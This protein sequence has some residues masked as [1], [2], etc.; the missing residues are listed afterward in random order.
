MSPR[1]STAKL[2]VE[3]K[4]SISSVHDQHVDSDSISASARPLGT[5][6]I[7]EYLRPN[8]DPCERLESPKSFI[9]SQNSSFEVSMTTSAPAL[10][11]HSAE[12]C[13]EKEVFSSFN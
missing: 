6:C 8:L 12:I 2:Q 11:I 4:D 5:V 3:R 1:H 10:R 9:Q 7:E 13:V